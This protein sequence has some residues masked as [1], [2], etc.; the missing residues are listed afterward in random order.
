MPENIVAILRTAEE[1]ELRYLRAVLGFRRV[2]LSKSRRP[3]RRRSALRS[4][5]A[6]GKWS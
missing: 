6:D 3:Q 4:L 1:A 5:I 2:N